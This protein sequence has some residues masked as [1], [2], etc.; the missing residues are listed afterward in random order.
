MLSKLCNGG[1]KTLWLPP[2]GLPDTPKCPE[3]IFS[4]AELVNLNFTIAQKKSSFSCS[5]F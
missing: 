4:Q 5:P 1:L 2:E 3:V